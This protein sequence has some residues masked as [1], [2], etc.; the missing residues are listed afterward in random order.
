MA[1]G[2]A[3]NRKSAHVHAWQ[4]WAEA[5]RPGLGRWRRNSST[6]RAKAQRVSEQRLAAGGGRVVK[7]L[8]QFAL[9][10]T[11]GLA[12][13]G[14]A[15]SAEPAAKPVDPMKPVDGVVSS[16]SGGQAIVA[17][18]DGKS[19]RVNVTAKT[20]VIGSQ[21]VD[22]S[23]IKPGAHV[24]T[25]NRDQ[26]DG[27]GVSSEVHLFAEPPPGG[28]TN[29][30]WSGGAMM[31]MGAVAQVSPSGDGRR[32]E[33]DYGAGRKTI[34]VSR[35]T[36]VVLLSQTKDTALIKPGATVKFAGKAEADGSVTAVFV[37][38]DV[39]AAPR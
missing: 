16:F 32:M 6:P 19:V 10:A 36:P 1:A 28:G 14:G 29:R 13:S 3:T 4:V 35:A 12:L 18:R 38:V 9:V 21:P 5:S 17:T 23:A 24:G 30:P 27:S 37:T 7:P 25:A 34:V 11:A 31:T 8:I 26:A 22:L 33:V 15:L 39:P 2:P 20:R